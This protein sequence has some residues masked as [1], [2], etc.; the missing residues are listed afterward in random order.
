MFY[1]LKSAK[2]TVNGTFMTI[3]HLKYESMH[4]KKN[5]Q[6]E[7]QKFLVSRLHCLLFGCVIRCF[8]R[9]S[10]VGCRL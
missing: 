5:Q 7:E 3:F 10:V 9:F 1:E 4:L 2:K 6:R 8:R